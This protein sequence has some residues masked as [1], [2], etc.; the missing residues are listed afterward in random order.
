MLWQQVSVLNACLL[1]WR[2]LEET[3]L[4]EVLTFCR[5]QDRAQPA[6][7]ARRARAGLREG[8]LV[9][10]ARRPASNG[11]PNYEMDERWAA[12]LDPL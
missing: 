3:R 2:H 12:R 10:R 1:G 6:R 11:A 8:H 5:R 9:G 4:V 7:Q